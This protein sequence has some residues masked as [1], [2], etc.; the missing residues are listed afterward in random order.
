MGFENNMT[1]NTWYYTLSTI[2][3][4]LAAILGLA[5]VFVVLRLQGLIKNISD[6]RGR[7]IDVLRVKEKH[8]QSYK[9]PQSITIKEILEDLREIDGNYETEY[10]RNAGVVDNLSKLSDR[11]EPNKGLGHQ[12]F[13]KDTLKNLDSFVSQRDDVVKLV[14]WPGIIVSLA[15]AISILLLGLTDWAINNSL[16]LL[17]LFVVVLALFGIWSIIRACW[18]ILFA[19]KTLE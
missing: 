5:A 6:Y 13:L 8:I 16:I 4:T 7:A 18:K 10:S 3:Q 11:Y 19:I 1:P 9:I 15:I 14:K 17:L 12:D 2:S